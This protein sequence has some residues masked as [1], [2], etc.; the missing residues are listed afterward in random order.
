[1][2]HGYTRG[3]RSSFF[4]FYDVSPL[5]VFVLWMIHIKTSGFSD[6]GQRTRGLDGDVNRDAGLGVFGIWLDPD[7]GS[8]ILQIFMEDCHTT[9][10]LHLR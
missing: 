8:A 9:I 10:I 2:S 4:Y 7:R 6:R 1:M 3:V 5:F